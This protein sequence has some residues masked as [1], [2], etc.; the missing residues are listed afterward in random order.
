MNK[1]KY[2]TPLRYPGGKSRATKKLAPFMP[3]L[4]NYKEFRDPFGGGGSVSLFVA[5]QYKNI[6]IWYNDLYEPLYN[7]W[8]ILQQDGMNLSDHLMDLKN[9]YHTEETA[10]MLFNNAK[11]SIEDG[12][13]DAF[14][15]AADFYIINKCS[16]SGLTESSSFSKQASVSNFTH[17]GIENLKAYFK[18]IKNWKITNLSYENLLTDD[19]KCFLYLDPPY[20]IESYLYGKQGDMHKEF[21]HDLF[22]KNCNK[23]KCNQL[24]SYNASQLIRNRFLNWQEGEFDHTYTLRSVGEY[25][26]DQTERK[27]L[28]LMNYP[29]YIACDDWFDELK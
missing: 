2:K 8:S 21:D 16:F 9:A 4:G 26:E 12:N 10:R 6:R 7:F 20:E 11:K 15:R 24:I 19:E 23:Y 25:L 29:H 18:I 13:R 27:E 14:L 5:A 22:A 3:H 1:V 28:V 17:R